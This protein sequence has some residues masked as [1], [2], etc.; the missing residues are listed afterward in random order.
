MTKEE[1]IQ[2]VKRLIEEFELTRKDYQAHSLKGK[3]IAPKFFG[4][5]GQTWSGRGLTPKWVDLMN[6]KFVEPKGNTQ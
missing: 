4:P 5:D 6:P 2:E 1:A 3:K